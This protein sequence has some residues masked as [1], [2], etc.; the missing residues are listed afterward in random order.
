M[1][2]VYRSRLNK[3]P[4]D[5]KVDVAGV[6]LQWGMSANHRREAILE[7]FRDYKIP[8]TEL[9]TGT[10]R[11]CVK[12]SN[13]ALK[14]ALDDEGIDDNRQEWV[15]SQRLAPD[16]AY[17][18]EISG[19]IIVK[20]DG[21]NDIQGGHLLVADYIPAFSSYGEMA[22]YQRPILKILKEWSKNNLLGDVGFTKKN[23]A[24]WGHKGNTPKCIDFAYVYPA[25]MSLFT[26]TCGCADLEPDGSTYSNYVCKHCKKI[27]TD[28][29]L[30][31]RIS[32]E[33]RHEFFSKVSGLRLTQEYEMIDV[34]PKY[35]HIERPSFADAVMINNQSNELRETF[36]K[37]SNR[38]W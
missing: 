25:G 14:V 12:Y 17:S 38:R 8:C 21:T 31:S 26:C 24:N 29:E 27:F 10:N 20:E 1:Q 33:K 15:M 13:F 28:S 4:E 36:F 34:D 37:Y 3:L 2:Q 7:A 18:H 19:D 6:V 11:L 22:M 23:Y 35:L 5:L 16:A 30:R 32:N 9:G